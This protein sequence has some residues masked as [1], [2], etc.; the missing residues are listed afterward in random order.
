MASAMAAHLP[1]DPLL[2]VYVRCGCGRRSTNVR[3]YRSSAVRIA[4]AE[5]FEDGYKIGTWWC[6]RCRS[7]GILT[8][9]AMHFSGFISA[10]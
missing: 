8:A 5:L 2:E 3:I 9:R 6:W 7:V 1:D 10:L 4:K